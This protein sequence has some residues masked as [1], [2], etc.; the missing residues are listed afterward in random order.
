MNAQ[1]VIN[2]KV[3]EDINHMMIPLQSFNHVMISKKIKISEIIIFLFN[4]KF[5]RKGSKIGSLTN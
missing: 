3:L 5:I 2:F 4:G 1:L